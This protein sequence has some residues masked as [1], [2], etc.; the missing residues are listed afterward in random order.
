MLVLFTNIIYYI[1][2]F[3]LHHTL[4]LLVNKTN[5]GIREQ[6]DCYLCV[7]QVRLLGRLALSRE[8]VCLARVSDLQAGKEYNFV[9]IIL[10]TPDSYIYSNSKVTIT[11]SEP[12]AEVNREV[13]LIRPIFV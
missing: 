3:I 5:N 4:Q 13:S 8:F 12:T 1:I 9:Y 7:E 11:F 6:K 10:A 2:R